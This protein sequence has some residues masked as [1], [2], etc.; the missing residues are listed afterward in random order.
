MVWT[1]FEYFFDLSSLMKIARRIG[2]GKLKIRFVTE[3]LIV[4]D[5]T[6]LK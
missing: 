2:Q 5:N 3:I 4:L 6:L 1:I